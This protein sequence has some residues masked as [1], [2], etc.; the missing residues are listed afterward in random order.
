MGKP[1]LVSDRLLMA[2]FVRLELY[3]RKCGHAWPSQEH[4]ADKLGYCV[5]Q[6][7]RGLKRLVELG[8]IRVRRTGSYNRVYILWNE[9]KMS[10]RFGRNVRSTPYIESELK[11]QTGGAAASTPAAD[12]LSPEPSA[13]GAEHAY[14]P[15][16]QLPSGG[17]AVVVLKRRKVPIAD[18]IVI[19]ERMAAYHAKEGIGH[20]GKIV[21][22]FIADQVAAHRD[23]AELAERKRDPD[24]RP[25]IPRQ[26]HDRP[27]ILRP[28]YAF[29]PRHQS[30]ASGAFAD[31]LREVGCL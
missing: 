31:R 21:H 6:L 29:K 28:Q 26:V 13:A 11:H 25:P 14:E 8:A 18:V 16:R 24:W 12:A 30:A 23:A 9:K 2:L 4:L 27:K 10:D 15:V 17:A 7:R 5:R 22:S 3:S 20:A 1:D 19:A